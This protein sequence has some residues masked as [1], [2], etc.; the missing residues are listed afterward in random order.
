MDPAHGKKGYMVDIAETVFVRAGYRIDFTVVPWSR[1]LVETEN[2][3]SDGIVGIYFIQARE[4]N[5]V[6]PSEEIGIS[7]NYFFV[8]SDSNW[9]YSGENSLKPMVLGVIADYDYGELNPYIKKLG[10]EKSHALQIVSGNEALEKNL[11]KL[12]ASRITLFIEDPVVVNY[13]ARQIGVD[14]QIKPAGMVQPRNRVGIAFSAKN[15]KSDDYARI[16]SEG[17][18]ALRK[19]GELKTILDVYGVRD[20]KT[21]ASGQET[22]S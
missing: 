13:V 7:T 11:K 18:Q 1:S 16:L 6:V 20:W 12:V 8:K 2:A 17:I 3:V 4:K 14:K 9:T 22:G 19:S 15:P 21:G 10:T 5:F